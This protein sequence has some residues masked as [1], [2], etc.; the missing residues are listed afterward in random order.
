[1]RTATRAVTDAGHDDGCV[2]R[3]WPQRCVQTP[4]NGG[5]I[6]ADANRIPDLSIGMD[7]LQHLHMYVVPGQGKIY[8]T[9]YE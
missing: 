8:L 3:Q 5:G 9:S 2:R 7:V 4:I 6:Q 1:M